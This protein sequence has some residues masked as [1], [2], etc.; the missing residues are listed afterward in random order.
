M[1]SNK[2][3][4]YLKFFIFLLLIWPYMGP[5]G[6]YWG[7]SVG[8]SCIL[9]GAIKQI[10]FSIPECVKVRNHKRVYMK[11]FLIAVYIILNALSVRYL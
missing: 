7:V 9:Y 10:W 3:K 4:K 6:D 11:G 5:W 8:L 1:L 2:D